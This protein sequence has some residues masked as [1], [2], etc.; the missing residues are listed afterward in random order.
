MIMAGAAAILTQGIVRE[1]TGT[2]ILWSQWF[3]A[4]LPASVLTI[5]IC[6]I[7]IL[8]LYPARETNLSASKDYFQQSLAAIGPWSA[9]E[10]RLLLWIVLATALWS[11]DFIDHIDPATMG[12][13]AGLLLVL[14]RF[15]V[16]DTEVLRRVN[17]LV[18]LFSAG[19]VSMAN[20]LAHTQALSAI[21]EHLIHYIKPLL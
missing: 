7:T 8:R 13:G 17:F 2:E 5:F 14:P 3:L 10:K 19:A 20:V 12:L 6:W 11:T 21:N 18:V 15:G 1:Q 9:A 16:L 4:F